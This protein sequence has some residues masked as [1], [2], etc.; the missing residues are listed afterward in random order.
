MDQTR[1]IIKFFWLHA[2]RYKPYVIGIL[3][4]T[5]LAIFFH[6]FL[7][8]LII[9]GILQRLATGNFVP[10]D[11]FGSFGPTLA[12]YIVVY[13]IG[14]VVLYRI[15]TFLMW[16][17]ETKVSRDIAEEVFSHLVH[18]EASFHANRQGGALVSQATRLVSA[19]ERLADTTI[20]ST[21]PLLL[22]FTFAAIVLLPRVPLYVLF[23]LSLAGIYLTIALISAKRIRHFNTTE[24]EA[25]GVQTGSLADSITNIM[26]VK[27]FGHE[28]YETS[29]FKKATQKTETAN[30]NLMKATLRRDTYFSLVGSSF[31]ITT[32]TMVIVAVMFL[33]ADISTAF[34]ML[35]YSLAI[36]SSLWGFSS[37]ALR[38][39]NRALG[40]AH[41]MI[42]ILKQ[43]PDITDPKTPIRRLKGSA[44]EFQNISFTHNDARKILFK[45]FDLSISEGEK[46]GLI[47]RSGSGKTT[48]T[49]LLL[50]F[51]DVDAGKITIAGQPITHITQKLLRETIAYVPQEPLLFHRSIAENIAYG[52]PGASMNAIRE[53]A[54]RASALEFIEELPQGF[55]TLVGE[56]GVK[57][58]GGQRQRIA[59]A[60]AILKDA[61]IL[62]L[63]EATSALDS[64]SEKAIQKALQKLMKGRTTVVVAHRLST[65]ASLDRIVVLDKGK[66]IEQGSHTKLLEK[67]GTYA[68]LWQ[69]Q[70]SGFIED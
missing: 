21:A 55:N 3:T 64:E 24:A 60:R 53:A 46:V 70:S 67:N 34:L 62:V 61:P 45:N 40:D 30:N 33:Q 66:V 9:S 36:A 25:V 49:K 2:W 65:I 12:L 1:E 7:S 18:L 58:S 44:I 68:R 26:T 39:Y 47:G 31:S 42:G 20:Y 56:R 11:F 57:L 41:D 15:L 63:D 37:Q 6:T 17:L 29:Q 22:I 48:L 14:N 59:I 13:L 10:N 50:R 51:A 32:I 4:V 43:S 28:Q 5:P 23:L 54:R 38:T 52:K 69:H 8:S 35:T 19:Y 16:R 27:S